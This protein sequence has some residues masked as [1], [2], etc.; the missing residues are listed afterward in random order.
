MDTFRT[1]ALSVL[2]A[3]ANIAAIATRH[4]ER[5]IKLW[6]NVQTLP[7]TQP[8]T[9]QNTKAFQRFKSPLQKTAAI[10]G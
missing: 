5:A 3:E 7:I 1:V 4:H 9:K 10:V 8:V 2:E 6:I